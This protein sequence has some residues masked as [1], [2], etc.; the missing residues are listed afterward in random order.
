M[1]EAFLSALL[2]EPEGNRVYATRAGARHVENR[3]GE[4]EPGQQRRYFCSE[5]S[6][7]IDNQG[8]K[9]DVQSWHF[10]NKQSVQIKHVTD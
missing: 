6:A 10:F 2:Y 4:A 9:P 5:P 7:L 3:K 1:R 8:L